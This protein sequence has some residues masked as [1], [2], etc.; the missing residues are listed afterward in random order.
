VLSSARRLSLDARIFLEARA[1][2]ATL[3]VAPADARLEIGHLVGWGRGR[4]AL[5]VFQPSS[6][7]TVS[8]RT[9]TLTARGRGRLL[10]RA[11]GLRVGAV[12]RVVEL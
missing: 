12:E 7:G 8:S 5:G 6:R 3:S 4:H 10:L 9:L 1:L 2:D 11:S